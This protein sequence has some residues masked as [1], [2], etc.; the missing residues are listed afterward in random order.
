MLTAWKNKK[1]F[2]NNSMYLVYLVD[3]LHLENIRWETKLSIENVKMKI[4]QFIKYKNY[5]ELQLKSET[6]IL[7]AQQSSSF[8]ISFLSQ[9]LLFLLVTYF[10]TVSGTDIPSSIC[11]IIVGV[12][13]VF[14]AL[15][16]P[17]AVKHFGYRKPLIASGFGM[18]LGT[19]CYMREKNIL[20]FK[21]GNP[22][23]TLPVIQYTT[24]VGLISY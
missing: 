3:V 11:S 7:G 4:K 24:A 18:S 20:R 13:M 2:N 19:V 21:S 14:S 17:L 8:Q 15:I 16:S 9:F 6:S 10:A 22:L 5:Y 23:F 12:I 1:S